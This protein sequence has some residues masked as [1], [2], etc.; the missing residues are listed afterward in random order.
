MTTSE[1]T[2][3]STGIGFSHKSVLNVGDTFKITHSDGYVAKET[4]SKITYSP[5]GQ[6]YYTCESCATYNESDLKSV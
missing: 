6:F 3:T 2:T 1:K 5:E 4:V